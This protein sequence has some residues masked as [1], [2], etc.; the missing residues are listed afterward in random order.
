MSRWRRAPDSAGVLIERLD[1]AAALFN[2]A[3]WRTHVLNGPALAMFD[4][5]AQHGSAS[6]EELGAVL[7][8]GITDPEEAAAIGAAIEPALTLLEATG[9]IVRAE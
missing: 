5:I 7:A 6:A 4:Q 8:A 1:S 9:L 3:T 2:P